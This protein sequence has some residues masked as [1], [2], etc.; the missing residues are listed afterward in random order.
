MENP[1]NRP[2]GFPL[3][4]DEA[5]K[6]TVQGDSPAFGRLGT[7]RTQANG[8]ALAVNI[9]PGQLCNLSFAPPRQIGKVDKVLKV[10][11]VDC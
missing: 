1:R 10:R 6:L 7:L 3:T 11:G 2:S 8:F 9:I 5:P 4:L